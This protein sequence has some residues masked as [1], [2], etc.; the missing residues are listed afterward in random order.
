MRI[1]ILSTED[2]GWS[3]GAS[4]QRN[5]L[6]ALGRYASQEQIFLL[7]PAGTAG[8]EGNDS[9][10]VHPLVL[11][12]HPQWLWQVN[13]AAR[14]ISG[15]DLLLRDDLSL[16]PGGVDLLFPG[17][18]SVG[19]RTAN[20]W[21]I[22]DFQ[23]LHM[24]EMFSPAALEAR[25]RDLV[26][27]IERATMV[28][29][30]SENARQDFCRVAPRHTAKARVMSFVA[31]VSERIYQVD[32]KSSLARYELPERFFYLPNQFWKH[33]NHL[34]VFQSLRL[35]KE[36]GIRPFVVCTGLAL[37]HRHPGYFD[38][39]KERISEWG[40]E[41]QIKFC[42]LVPS[43][44][45]HLLVRQAI[46]VINP[47][48]FEG[49]STTV[50]EAKS[51]GKQILLSDLPVHHEQNAPESVYFDPHSPE[52]LAPKLADIW[53]EAPAGPDEVLEQRART[54]LPGRIK[55]YADTFVS[56]AQQAIDIRK[57]GRREIETR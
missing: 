41:D 14:R 47:S 40:L 29:L 54:A 52:E 45:V 7:K 51:I 36:R 37:D 5:L 22:P 3:G 28:V 21:W 10:N 56:I 27:G 33:K 13:R 9:P 50:E 39:V 23:H 12:G 2:S 24:P 44:H 1:G 20:V 43:E 32:L 53:A 46:C 16:V 19:S 4:Y 38:Q 26:S 17:F 6:Y 55:S 42:G 8:S 18:Y 11:P 49:W 57:R 31:A 48:L 35:L 25:R 15:Y 34:V 30:S